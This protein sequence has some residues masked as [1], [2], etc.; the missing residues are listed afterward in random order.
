MAIKINKT[1]K[2]LNWKELYAKEPV[3]KMAWYHVPLDKD[4]AVALSDLELTKGRALDI[5]TGPAT[6]AIALA[7]MGF[8]VTGTDLSAAAVE[9]AN[10]RAAGEGVKVVFKEDDILKT[11]IK[12][13]FEIVFDRGCL[14]VLPPKRRKEYART[15]KGLVK[16][17]GYLFVKTFS[18]REEG[19]WG[20]YRF[21]ANELRKI[22]KDTFEV[23]DIRETR[24]EGT[25]QWEPHAIFTTLK[26]P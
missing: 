23:V 8:K 19:E 21:T 2:F 17:G 16:K 20:P 14:H 9:K 15:L 13:P 10:E 22:F 11:T 3:E 7:K 26:R 18:Y 6:Q 1:K 24:F 4:L 5:G 12:G 25:L